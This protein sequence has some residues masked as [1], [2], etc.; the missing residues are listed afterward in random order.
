M[1]FALSS[2]PARMW[3]VPPAEPPVI[4]TPLPFSWIA[5]S[6][7]STDLYGESAGTTSTSSSAVSRAIGVVSSSRAVD[8]FVSTAPTMTR[9]V[10]IRYDV[11]FS[12]ASFCRPTVPPAPP[13]LLTCTDP[14]SFAPDTAADIARAVWSQPPP[15]SAGA[16]ISSLLMA[17]PPP[18]LFAA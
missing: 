4:D 18:E 17:S 6:R 8:A 13:T 15:G 10:I 11:D 3:S 16:M 5:A 1:S 12:F 9:P 7:S 2:S 14:A